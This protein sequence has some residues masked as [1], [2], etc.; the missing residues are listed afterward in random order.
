MVERRVMKVWSGRCRLHQ[1]LNQQGQSHWK[2]KFL[3]QRDKTSRRRPT[4]KKIYGRREVDGSG[5]NDEFVIYSWFLTRGILDGQGDGVC[6]TGL[7]NS[8]ALT[9]YWK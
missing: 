4:R 2:W 3:P 1:I 6:I 8:M 7:I 9:V 5:A